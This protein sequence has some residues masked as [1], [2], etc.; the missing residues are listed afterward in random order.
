[1]A[2]KVYYPAFLSLRGKSSV[3]IGGGKVAERK[4]LGLIKAGSEVVIISP[5]LTKRLEREKKGG[6][7][8]H[9]CR[10]YR[11]GDLKNAFLVIAATDTF[12]INKQISEDSPCL[13]NVV[14]TPELCNFI[15]PSVMNLGPLNIAVSTSGISPALSGSIRKELEEL[16][17]PEFHKYL[18]LLK[19]IRAKAMKEI[20]DNRQ[21]SEFLKAVASEKTV[22]ILRKKGYREAKKVVEELF[23]KET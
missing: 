12:S 1:M 16:F 3:V 7:V 9:I 11:K 18:K 2:P 17:K 8:K 23:K 10:Q 5:Y 20:R 14:D 22:K 13:V 21:R 4:V 19:K 15:V 6:R